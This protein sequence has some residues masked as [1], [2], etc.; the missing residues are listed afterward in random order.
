[1]FNIRDFFY[2][3]SSNDFVEIAIK[4]WI[5]VLTFWNIIVYNKKDFNFEFEN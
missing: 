2:N 4:F 3:N 1:M 5:K